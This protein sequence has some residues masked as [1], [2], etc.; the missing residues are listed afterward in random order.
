MLF[1][2]LQNDLIFILIKRLHTKPVCTWQFRNLLFSSFATTFFQQTNIKFKCQFNSISIIC[3]IY[4]IT[5]N[6]GTHIIDAQLQL[7]CYSQYPNALKLAGENKVQITN[8][9]LSWMPFPTSCTYY[10][11]HTYYIIHFHKV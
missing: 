9:N 2:V 1:I 11:K 8:I 3:Q 10:L 7:M 5:F 6:I 4:T